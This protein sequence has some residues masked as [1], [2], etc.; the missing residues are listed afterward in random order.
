MKSKTTSVGSQKTFYSNNEK[1]VSDQSPAM[2][3][4]TP[5]A[6]LQNS[7]PNTTNGTAFSAP[8]EE[9]NIGFIS[10]NKSPSVKLSRA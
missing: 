6:R 1:T 3:V 4:G 9:V 5:T 2:Q 7:T 10:D 8:T